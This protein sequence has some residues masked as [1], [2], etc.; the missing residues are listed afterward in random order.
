M[1]TRQLFKSYRF[2]ARWCGC[3]NVCHDLPSSQGAPTATRRH[4]PQIVISNFRD[5][6]GAR[7][8][9]A[10]SAVPSATA[11]AK[12]GKAF[13]KIAFQS[14]LLQI[15]CGCSCCC[16]CSCCLGALIFSCSSILKVQ[17]ICLMPAIWV[18][19]NGRC[20][21]N[22]RQQRWLLLPRLLIDWPLTA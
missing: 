10:A 22:Y 7:S 16:C 15:S 2:A 4:Q 14:Q 18:K 17:F 19:T 20:K 12:L 3:G 13:I 9:A 1:L 6:L 11:A 21:L 8:P 5:V